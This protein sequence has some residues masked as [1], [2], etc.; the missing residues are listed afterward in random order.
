MTNTKENKIVAEYYTSLKTRQPSK[1]Q[2]FNRRKNSYKSF[3]Q[4]NNKKLNI[5]KNI[6]EVTQMRNRNFAIEYLNSTVNKKLTKTYF[7][8]SKNISR[9]S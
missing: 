7:C 1:L 8:R 2:Q 6:N 4:D 3:T 5:P 9:N